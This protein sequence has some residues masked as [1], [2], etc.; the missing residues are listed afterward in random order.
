MAVPHRWQFIEYATSLTRGIILRAGR[1]QPSTILRVSS[2]SVPALVLAGGASR[3]MGSPK[4][5]LELGGRTFLACVLDALRDQGLVPIVV[6]TGPHHDLV[7]AS[8]ARDPRAGEVRVTRN[9]V[10]DADQL[11]SLVHGLDAVDG[12]DVAGVLVAL[13][14]HPLVSRE[15]VRAL[16]A[17]FLATRAPVAR[18]ICRGRHGHPAIFARETFDALRAGSAHGAKS[19]V[20]ALADRALSVE[21]EDEGIWTDID[22]PDAYRAARVRAG[23]GP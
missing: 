10:P 5:L 2:V 7:T 13:V 11:S 15:T 8:L 4:A 16:V 6:V 17:G 1:R 12:P 22:T 23:D 18:P 9:T 14:D 20:R 21:V 3:R 19:V